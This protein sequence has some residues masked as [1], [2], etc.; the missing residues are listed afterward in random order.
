MRN[1]KFT[2]LLKTMSDMHERKNSD[3][4]EEG[5]PYSNFELSGGLAT[6]FTNPADVS[7]AVLLGVKMARLQ[8]LLGKGKTPKNE[9]VQDTLLDLAVYAAL[10]ASYYG[11]GSAAESPTNFPTQPAPEEQKYAYGTNAHQW[12]P[13]AAQSLGP[14]SL[15]S[16]R[17][18]PKLQR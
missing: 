4:S 12:P 6:K 8:E 16:N 7:F 2:S 10:W 15:P 3:Y 18:V 1:P 9:S 14:T 11:V 5:N 17:T 13:E